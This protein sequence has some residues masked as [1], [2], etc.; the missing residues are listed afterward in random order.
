MLHESRNFALSRPSGQ[1]SDD[2]SPSGNQERQGIRS[3]DRIDQAP[4]FDD[5]LTESFIALEPLVAQGEFAKVGSEYSLT[6]LISHVR[7]IVLPP[8]ISSMTQ[9]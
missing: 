7:G 3:S 8:L 6:W 5:V 9:P 4:K 1:V 2:R